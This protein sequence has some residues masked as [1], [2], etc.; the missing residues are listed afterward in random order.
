MIPSIRPCLGTTLPSTM[1]IVS[2][3][4]DDVEVEDGLEAR[5]TLFGC[6]PEGHSICLHVTNVRPWIRL[7]LPSVHPIWK[8]RLST[9]L[10]KQHIDYTIELT[11]LSRFFG[12]QEG[13]EGKTKV[14]QYATISC[15][16]YKS[17][18][19]LLNFFKNVSVSFEGFHG[20]LPIVDSIQK[21]S[22]KSMNDKSMTWS[23]WISFS[24][25]V[26]TESSKE[27]HCQVEGYADY[28]T[29][30]PLDSDAIAPLVI[31]S[32]DAE[33][34][35][36]DGLFPD[37]LK[38]D[39]TTH[40]GMS[41]MQYGR[42]T[43]T[44]LVICV[45]EATSTDPDLIV[46][47]VQHSK[48][49]LET[50]S[51]CIRQIDPDIVTGWNIYGYDFPFLHKEYETHFT[52]PCRRGYEH[53]HTVQHTTSSLLHMYRE[54]CGGKEG[55]SK[56]RQFLKSLEHTVPIELLVSLAKAERE[57]K[58]TDSNLL[59]DDSDD[60]S[61]TMTSSLPES[62]AVTIRSSLRS[63][64][65]L[66]P[67]HSE[68]SKL[69]VELQTSYD[70]RSDR[71]GL[72][73]GRYKSVQST[74]ESKRMSSSA[75]G[76]NTYYYWGMIGRI[77]IDMMQVIK[78]DKKPESC[79][80]RYAA[81]TW[82]QHDQEKID[83]DAH[84]MF[85]YFKSGDPTKNGIIADYC[86]RD[87]DIPL[88]LIMKL[89]YIASWTEMSRVCFTPI[90]EVINSGQQIK[91]FNLIS[92]F[93]HGK[94][95]IN[96]RPSGWPLESS[97]EDDVEYGLDSKRKKAEYQGATVIEPS[98][99]FYP[100]PVSTLDFEGLYPSIMRFFNLC[101]STLVLDPI[102][103]TIPCETHTIDFGSFQSKFTFVSHVKGVLPQL[104][105]HLK[106]CRD[107]AKLAMKN[108]TTEND[109]M[110]QN[111]RQNGIKTSMNS[112]YGFC[113][114]A[115]DRGIL[116]CRPVAAVVTLKGRVFI[117]TTRQFV[118]DT[119]EG[120]RVIYGDTDSVMIKWKQ[121]TTVEHAFELGE[122]AASKV[123]A[124]LRSAESG[125][126]GASITSNTDAC[127]AVRLTNE[128]V[129][130][131]YLLFLKKN[132]AGIRCVPSSTGFSRTMDL[133]G[134]DPVRRDRSKLVRDTCSN[135][136]NAM[137]IHRSTEAAI[138]CLEDTLQNILLNT[139]PYDHYVL[140]RSIKS[141]YASNAPHN[142]ARQRMIE[143]G[144]QN[145]P[146]I[147]SRMPYLVLAD[148]SGLTKKCATKL[149]TRAEHPD[150]CKGKKLDLVYYTESL[151]PSMEKLFQFTTE[152]D[153]IP[154][155]FKSTIQTLQT[156]KRGF[157]SLQRFL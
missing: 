21:Y 78:D 100:E 35:S 157:N 59:E 61:N 127:S 133:K 108:A 82:L 117:E 101:P 7:E 12:W 40:L 16:N 71:P 103:T 31:L 64:L 58:R 136:L 41:I 123:T 27:S 97:N 114:T 26:L 93:V 36:H 102:S 17:C 50:F 1:M 119:Y 125:I 134:I 107:A 37:P 60:E 32:F 6:S 28:N 131:G 151:Q 145:V 156:K 86:S 56:V 55:R 15:A 3:D 154:S 22:T 138:R 92:R 39:F 57:F 79:S 115:A 89:G 13:I 63:F 104:L 66:E 96:K 155:L 91:V 44:R 90:Q 45:G 69:P 132:Y 18:N 80:L 42:P 124:L 76:E 150:Y 109:R 24:I 99:G 113:G 49:L 87:C 48:E 8:S 111:A 4:T 106:K 118:H 53:H 105:R 83:L 20:K 139:I 130:D 116:S 74:L 142:L 112:V 10:D 68:D 23:S 62:I 67:E 95:V 43:I 81:Q 54:Q 65:G 25:D 143:R 88:N 38:G 34:Y 84:T 52:A 135:V 33:M 148:P 30:C 94:Y 140:S 9:L 126:G 110:I 14:Y 137:L 29:L 70:T 153:K 152:K 51:Q 5:L 98:P 85:A 77:T 11:L 47:R 2:G 120:S 128:K 19:K 129:Y 149:Y 73:L 144:D 46:L 72:Y 122:D 75:R 147:G 141:S 146:P 121:G